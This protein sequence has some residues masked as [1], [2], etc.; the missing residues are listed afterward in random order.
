VVL[1]PGVHQELHDILRQQSAAMG[2]FDR[3]VDMRGALDAA[4]HDVQELRQ[5]LKR[6]H[7]ELERVST[8]QADVQAAARADE[9]ALLGYLSNVQR[10][11]AG[12]WCSACACVRVRVRVSV[13]ACGRVLN[14]MSGAVAFARMRM[15]AL[16]GDVSCTPPT[17]QAPP[18]WL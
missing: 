10:Q 4:Q 12:S 17:P 2:S 9:A 16:V 13:R 14:N 11:L 6:A 1:D 8:A 7:S 18:P 5:Q 3:V 15:C